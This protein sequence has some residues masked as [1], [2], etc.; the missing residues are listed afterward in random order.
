MSLGQRNG[1][2]TAIVSKAQ[3]RELSR[4]VCSRECERTKYGDRWHGLISQLE[5]GL[6]VLMGWELHIR[7][8]ML[9]III[10]S[11]THTLY[12]LE[13]SS[14]YVWYN[15]TQVFDSFCYCFAAL[16]KIISVCINSQDPRYIKSQPRFVCI[17]MDI[18]RAS[19][20]LFVKANS[21]QSTFHWIRK[22]FADP[23]PF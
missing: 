13:G 6:G 21:L 16:A 4:E 10:W 18:I 14:G 22:D 23:F 3:H 9:S 8:Y 5:Y 17:R 12:F 20:L 11:M 1:S 19:Q 2:D 15:P 7:K